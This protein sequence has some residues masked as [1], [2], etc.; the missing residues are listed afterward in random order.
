MTV[1]R[2]VTGAPA[3]TDWPPARRDDSAECE[4][5]QVVAVSTQSTEP[6]REVA[7]VRLDASLECGADGLRML[8]ACA[9]W[10][11][12]AQAAGA[13]DAIA[14]ARSRLLPAVE[15]SALP[16]R[17]AQVVRVCSSVMCDLAGQGWLLKVGAPGIYAAQPNA[18]ASWAE[19]KT[20]VRTAHLIERDSQLAQP[21]TRRFIQDMERRRPTRDGWRSIFTLMRDGRPLR[22]HLLAASA[23]DTPEARR[24]ALAACVQ[25]YVQVV[26]PSAV[27]HVTGLRLMDVWR[28]FRHT[29]TTTYNSTPG[30]K[31]Y[32]L[33]RDRAVPEHPVIG[34]AALGSAI[35]QMSERDRWIGWSSDAFLAELQQ[36][37][38]SEWARWLD[39]SLDELLAGVYTADLVRDGVFSRRELRA[40]TGDTVARLR[41]A[42]RE[43]RNTHRLYAQVAQHKATA[44]K[45]TSAAKGRRKKKPGKPASNDAHWRRQA[46]THLFK[47]KRA[48]ALADLLEARVRL[49]A[50]GFDGPTKQALKTALS[51]PAGRRAV[52]TVLRRVRAAHVGIDMLDITVCG[53]V[54]PY[55]VLLGG[56]LV[57]MLMASPEIVAA[58]ARRYRDACSVIASA[59][60]ARAIRRRP[61]LVLLGTTSLYGVASSQYNR[62]RVPAG[63]VGAAGDVEFIRLG[64]TAGFG[65]YHF[66]RETIAELEA[67][68][69]SVR[70]GREVN[71]IFGEG[72]NPKLRKVRGALD[73]V[74]LP[75]EALLQHGSP[76]L[77]YGVP[78]ASNF[79]EVLLGRAKRPKYLLPQAPDAAAAEAIAAYW[80]ER[81]LEPRV[82]RPDVLRA[83]AEHSLS[84]PVT[85]GA[86]VT[87]PRRGD[88]NDG[89]RDMADLFESQEAG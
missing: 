46:L 43:A 56:K 61:N 19:E 79:R 13:A 52:Q 8:R 60:A 37:P 71:S 11:R 86:R 80:R 57:S 33:I 12:I 69:A 30:R 20:R 15:E 28:Y 39:E 58:Y 63:K 55:T 84:F 74:G 88:E 6:V 22:D 7:W 14:A 5:K 75:S 77:I 45:V 24:S 89:P 23:A 17:E 34:I 85:H 66:S 36:R 83:V 27:D 9:R 64:R 54:A 2:P 26:E 21:A 59:M 41:A 35:V 50:S 40:S 4:A 87:L 72:V 29:W 82:Q 81:W 67:V 65:S 38:S 70:R 78:L 76:R 25:P 32:V 53:A 16:P 51:K 47:S 49:A 73:S 10:L 68:A 42:S 31:M 44:R 3:L 62:V 18:A 48:T 1:P